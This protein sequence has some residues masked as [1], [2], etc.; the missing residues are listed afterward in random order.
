MTSTRLKGIA[1]ECVFT[2]CEAHPLYRKI[3]ELRVLFFFMWYRLFLESLYQILED[4]FSSDRCPW[5]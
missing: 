1:S 3:A 4:R 5:Y 2:V